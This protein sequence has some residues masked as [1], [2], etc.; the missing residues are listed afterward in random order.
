MKEFEFRIRDWFEGCPP[1]EFAV[2]NNFL[3]VFV[4]EI[5]VSKLSNYSNKSTADGIY[6]PLYPIAEWLVTNWWR[7]LYEC[8][9]YRNND[10]EYCHN[11]SFA[12]EGYF[13][14]DIRF[15]PENDI[16]GIEWKPRSINGDMLS[17]CDFGDRTVSFASVESEFKCFINIVLIGCQTSSSFSR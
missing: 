5:L 3:S 12:G 15:L 11:L 9:N 10:F 7:L 14:P 2:T 16:I 4:D 17:F 1:L 8:N 6:L 13:L